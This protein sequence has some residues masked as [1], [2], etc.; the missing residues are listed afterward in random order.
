MRSTRHPRAIATALAL[1][2]VGASG[3]GGEDPTSPRDVRRVDVDATA[4]ASVSDEAEP[5][6][7]TRGLA[8]AVQEAP[9]RL[10]GAATDNYKAS[11]N[12]DP[13][14]PER[15]TWLAVYEL[16]FD[17]RRFRV[18]EGQKLVQDTVRLQVVGGDEIIELSPIVTDGAGEARMRIGPQRGLWGPLLTLEDAPVDGDSPVTVVLEQVDDP[19]QRVT[20]TYARDDGLAAAP[21]SSLEH[22][23]PGG[24]W[25][26][27]GSMTATNLEL[28][29]E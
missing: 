14:A 26:V 29:W 25:S 24:R 11:F 28:G 15:R 27:D 18:V 12:E 2:T 21:R 6:A 17:G 16:E 9:L 8:C 7:P 20:L 22:G 4:P 13:D 23:G 5:D 10:C 1:A 19:E 3:C